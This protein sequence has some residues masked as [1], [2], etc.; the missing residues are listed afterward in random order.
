VVEVNF[1]GTE[2]E[3]WQLYPAK[4]DYYTY[5][6]SWAESVEAEQIL[7]RAMGN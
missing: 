3:S 4:I 5:Q 1:I 2:I 6:P 7:A